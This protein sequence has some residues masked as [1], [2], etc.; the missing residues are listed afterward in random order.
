M[1][2]AKNLKERKIVRCELELLGAGRKWL[3]LGSSMNL[4]IPASWIKGI[5]RREAEERQFSIINNQKFVKCVVGQRFN[6]RI[7]K[8]RNAYKEFWDEREKKWSKP[9]RYIPLS[10]TIKRTY[11]YSKKYQR[12]YGTFCGNL[13]CE[14]RIKKENKFEIICDV[15]KI[16]GCAGQFYSYAS[17]AKFTNG[18]MKDGKFVFSILFD[19][20]SEDE[21]EDI[22]LYN[23]LIKILEVFENGDTILE[24]EI[25][26]KHR[27]NKSLGFSLKIIEEKTIKPEDYMGGV[28]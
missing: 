11:T 3:I 6:F 16:F 7:L 25:L 10:A 2:K 24:K 23:K 26:S 1:K 5:V 8:N 20:S 27:L 19:I 22:R 14:K 28:S 13:R 4:H 9:T 21:K 15:C 17:K 12:N 18:Y